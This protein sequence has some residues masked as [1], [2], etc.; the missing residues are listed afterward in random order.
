[1][2]DK[3]GE[4]NVS[5]ADIVRQVESGA[6]EIVP[7]PPSLSP[8]NAPSESHTASNADRD[9][10]TVVENVVNVNSDEGIGSDAAILSSNDG[11]SAEMD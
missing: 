9:T 3:S 11:I 7:P 8:K 10:P 1:M 5:A 2:K 6:D 4:G